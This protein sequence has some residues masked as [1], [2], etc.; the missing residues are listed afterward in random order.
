MTTYVYRAIW[1]ITDTDRTVR[2]LIAEACAGLDAMANADG[3]RIV[4][5]PV[6]TVSGDRLVCEAP[7]EPLVDQEVDTS[8]LAD[9]AAV[10]IRLAGLHWSDGQIATTTGIPRSTVR[11]I[12]AR[13][14]QPSE[15]TRAA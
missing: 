6:W 1:P 9:P 12:L 10:V 15:E 8:D 5:D 4:G 3:A 11:S 14:N 2:S 7:A 13:H